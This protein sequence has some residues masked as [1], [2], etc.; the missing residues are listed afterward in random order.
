MRLDEIGRAEI[1]QLK[2]TLLTRKTRFGKRRSKK[3]INNILST[4]SKILSYAVQPGMA[5]TSHRARPTWQSGLYRSTGARPRR[6]IWA[7][8]LVKP[9]NQPKRKP[10]NRQ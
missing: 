5:C 9:R 1:E 3:T 10:R 2:A 8:K 7:P 4:V 6:P